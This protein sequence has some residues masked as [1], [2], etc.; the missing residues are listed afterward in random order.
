LQLEQKGRG[1]NNCKDIINL[2]IINYTEINKDN[3]I[4]NKCYNCREYLFLNDIF[5]EDN[6]CEYNSKT[7]LF[8]KYFD[9]YNYKKYIANYNNILINFEKTNNC[10][11]ILPNFKL[12]V[13]G[14]DYFTSK[15]SNSLYNYENDTKFYVMLNDSNI[16]P[17]KGLFKIKKKIFKFLKKKQPPTNLFYKLLHINEPLVTRTSNNIDT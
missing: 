9:I 14:N 6:I 5:P 2:S 10:I 7:Y 17:N 16:I 3:K 4:E 13:V 1:I 11:A 15:L 8:I 12:S